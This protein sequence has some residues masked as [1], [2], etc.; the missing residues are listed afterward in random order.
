ME[1]AFDILLKR[2]AIWPQLSPSHIA[3]GPGQPK[4]GESMSESDSLVHSRNLPPE[5]AGGLLHLPRARAAWGWGSF[6]VRPPAR[7]GMY[8]DGTDRQEAACCLSGR[9]SE[10]ELG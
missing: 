4:N 1:P 7:G 5:Q 10:R 9:V 8:S 2:L 3:V 6:F